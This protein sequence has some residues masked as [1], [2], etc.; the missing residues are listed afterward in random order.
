MDV[1][2]LLIII[3]A[4]LVTSISPTIF[5]ILLI[6]CIVLILSYQYKYNKIFNINELI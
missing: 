6:F 1:E 2:V 5:I 4:I 3:G